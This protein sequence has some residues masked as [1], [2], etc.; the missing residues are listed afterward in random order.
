MKKSIRNGLERSRDDE[1]GRIFGMEM[2][3]YGKRKEYRLARYESE[4]M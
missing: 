1:I 3:G 2:N 4:I